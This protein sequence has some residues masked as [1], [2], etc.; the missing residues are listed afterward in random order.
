[1]VTFTLTIRGAKSEPERKEQNL[2]GLRGDGENPF[3]VGTLRFS[4]MCALFH[5]VRAG[6]FFNLLL[7]KDGLTATG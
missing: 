4:T 6:L 1:M 5:Q 2:L 7:P 3:R